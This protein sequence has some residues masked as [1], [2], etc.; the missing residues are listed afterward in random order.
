MLDSGKP[1]ST[2]ASRYS[3]GRLLRNCTGD[4]SLTALDFE[5]PIVIAS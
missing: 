2:G 3:S 4:T 5:V 1:A